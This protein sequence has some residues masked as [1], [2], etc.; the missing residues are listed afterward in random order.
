MIMMKPVIIAGAGGHTRVLIASLSA[1]NRRILGILDP[2]PSIAGHN[3]AGVPVVGN[4]DRIGDF[5]PTSVEIVNG[6][7]SIKSTET[8]RVLFQKFKNGGYSFAGVVHPTALVMEDVQMGEGVQILAGAIVQ[9]GCVIGDNVIIN[10]GAVI[11]HDCV[12]GAHVHVAPGAVL[13]GAVEIGP[14]AHIGTAAAIIQGIK[15]GACAVVGAG[16]VVI[17]DVPANVTVAGV[18]A[19]LVER[20]R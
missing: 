20:R 6:I 11:D 5:A 4:D 7:G 19:R 12:I 10:T 15:I 18:P 1:L 8:R 2:D 17:D 3:I 14:M 16:A 13:S 9:T